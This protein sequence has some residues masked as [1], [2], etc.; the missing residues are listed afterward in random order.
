MYVPL[1]FSTKSPLSPNINSITGIYQYREANDKKGRVNVFC[2]NKF[3]H[4]ITLET[5]K[6]RDKELYIMLL[7]Q[8]R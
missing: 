1:N 4:R 3:Y 6:F 5:I 2:K 8:I 7:L